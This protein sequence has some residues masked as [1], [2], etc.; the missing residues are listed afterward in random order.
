MFIVLN[1]NDHD[2]NWSIYGFRDT[3]DEAAQLAAAKDWPPNPTP[4]NF[5]PMPENGVLAGCFHAWAGN[6]HLYIIPVVDR[7]E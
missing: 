2:N 1:F 3:Y 7:R 4:L 5:T 6:D